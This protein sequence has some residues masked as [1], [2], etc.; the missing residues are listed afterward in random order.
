LDDKQFLIFITI[1][2]AVYCSIFD[3]DKNHVTKQVIQQNSYQAHALSVH[4][5]HN[6]LRQWIPTCLKSTFFIKSE[7][8]SSLPRLYSLTQ[9]TNPE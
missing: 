9:N 4:C 3:Y 5:E 1:N 7:H 2:G 8:H 6:S